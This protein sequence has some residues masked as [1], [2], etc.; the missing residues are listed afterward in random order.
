MAL[1]H[2][3]NLISMDYVP[4]AVWLRLTLNNL[5]KGVAKLKISLQFFAIRAM[6]S[7]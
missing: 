4:S 3:K 6:L 1:F 5:P 2:A 7:I